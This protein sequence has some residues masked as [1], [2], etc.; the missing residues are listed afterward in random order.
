MPFE[1]RNAPQS[2]QRFMDE[3]IPG[4][5][6][7]Y[8]YIDDL[9]IAS[10]TA[11]E[12]KQHLHILFARL[13]EYGVIINPAKC[14]SGVSNLDFLGHHVDQHGIRPLE[15][16]VQ[17]I[18]DF[19]RPTSVKQLRRI[20]GLVNFYRRFVSKAAD[21]LAPLTDALR[22]QPK[23]STKPINWTDERA[24]AFA[25]VKEVLADT[26]MLIHPASH[27]PTSLMVDNNNNNDKFL[28]SAFQN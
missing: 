25:R 8:T 16:K 28:Y 6:F 15:E 20:L 23:R 22:D 3:V 21:I 1:L 19:P 26:A 27:L 4:L 18:R 5:L 9:L 11:E 13:S 17:T 14:V 12:H 24:S 10:E 7:V 2:F